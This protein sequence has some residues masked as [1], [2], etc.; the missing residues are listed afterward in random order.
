MLDIKTVKPSKTNKAR[1]A[2]KNLTE[3]SY[4]SEIQ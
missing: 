4:Y 3:K 2:P 1:A